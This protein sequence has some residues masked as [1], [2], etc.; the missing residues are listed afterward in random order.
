MF[1]A[2]VHLSSV[3]VN[4]Q[5]SNELDVDFREIV[6]IQSCESANDKAECFYDFIEKEVIKTLKEEIET[7]IKK[8]TVW[9]GIS[10]DVDKKGRLGSKVN[11]SVNTKKARQ[12]N[13]RLKDFLNSLEPYQISTKKQK[14]LTIRHL[15]E[16]RYSYR[17]ENKGVYKQIPP[18]TPYSGG[19]F[20]EWAS[21]FGEKSKNPR[22]RRENLY[23]ELNN[24]IL[25]NFLIY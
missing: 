3:I 9:V 24:Y 5:K 11:V 1:F 7:E 16:F 18:E 13:A 23:Q 20:Y 21:I 19:Q 14:R 4:A 15:M 25:N 12:I 17:W 10:F 8:D 2:I 6:T 22:T